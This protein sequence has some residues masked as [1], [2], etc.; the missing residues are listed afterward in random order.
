MA[1]SFV[2]QNSLSAL[3]SRKGSLQNCLLHCLLLLVV[4]LGFSLFHLSEASNFEVV[5][6]FFENLYT[7]I[8]KILLHCGY[9]GFVYSFVFFS[10]RFLYVKETE[11]VR[12]SISKLQ[13]QVVTYVFEL[14]AEN[15]HR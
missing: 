13:I 6:R 1:G 7:H 8:F 11:Y 12:K 2:L 9:L 15:C 3:Y 14:S 4:S 10:I 5:P